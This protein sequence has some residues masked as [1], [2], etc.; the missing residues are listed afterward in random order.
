MKWNL[1]KLKWMK[2]DFYIDSMENYWNIRRKMA[3]H[4]F[5]R[6]GTHKYVEEKE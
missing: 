6:K 2:N 5:K 4:E 3:V 1:K